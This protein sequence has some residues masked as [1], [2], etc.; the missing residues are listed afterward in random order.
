MKNL[1]TIITC[2]LI[3]SLLF[4]S[5]SGDD[6]KVFVPT[7]SD[8][9][10][11]IDENPD[12]GTII[13]IVT[14]NMTG[15]LIYTITSQSISDAFSV[16][17]NGEVSITDRSKFDFETNPQITAFIGIT[18]GTEEATSEVLVSLNNIDDIASFLTS[19][20]SAYEAA[21]TN[22]WILITKDEYNLL[23]SNLNDVSRVGTTQEQYDV[24]P[25]I[26]LNSVKTFANNNG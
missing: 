11:T 4:P 17:D 10:V 3:T 2:I 5:C 22:D 9:S 23:A 26:F 12:L 18:N 14:T 20:K 1:K 15:N 13:G 16:N 6:N 7:A 19:S 21:S 25:T 8:I 24:E